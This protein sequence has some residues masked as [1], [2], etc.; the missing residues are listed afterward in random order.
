MNS[1]ELK[2]HIVL[3]DDTDENVSESII[4]NLIN[5]GLSI[6]TF[7]EKEWEL[8]N[9]DL[10]QQR[11]ENIISEIQFDEI[12]SEFKNWIKTG[13]ENIIQ[14]AYIITKHRYPTIEKAKIEENI[15]NIKNSVWLELHDNLTA[16]EKVRIINHI[17][18]STQKFKGQK[19]YGTDLKST[20]LN[21]VLENKKGSPIMLSIIFL[22]IAQRL[23]IPIKGVNLINN[24]ILAYVDAESARIAYPENKNDVLFYINPFNRGSVFDSKE[25]DLYLEQLEVEKNEKF[26]TPISNIDAIRAMILDLI[27]ISEFK[28]NEHLKSQLKHLYSVSLGV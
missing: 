3:L 18:F 2:A 15:E 11:I 23:Q 6:I 28:K 20:Y 7:L 24:F 5:E 10:V 17:L 8:S 14:G 9:N 1:K 16:L 21:T 13:G 27:K 26:Y 12:K 25:I 22:A 19:S 4:Q